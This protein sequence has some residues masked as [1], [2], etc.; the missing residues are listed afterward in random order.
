MIIPFEGKIS[1]KESLYSDIIYQYKCFST[2]I[3]LPNRS[4]NPSTY[5]DIDLNS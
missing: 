1:H 3:Y 5:V 2:E 4:C